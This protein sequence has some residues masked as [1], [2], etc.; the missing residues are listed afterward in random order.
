MSIKDLADKMR[1]YGRGPDDVLVHMSKKE[2]RS[3]QGLAQAAG[4]SLTVNPKT[5]LPEAGFLDSLLPTIIGGAVGVMTMN[6]MAGAA[7][8]AAVGGYQ[9]KDTQL[10]FLGGAALGAMGGYGGAN[11]AGGLANTGANA[12]ATQGVVNAVPEATL[13]QEAAVSSVGPVQAGAA[14]PLSAGADAAY[15]GAADTARMNYNNMGAMDRFSQGA[16]AAM[17]NPYGYIDTL[18]GGTEAAKTAGMAAAPAV[19][20]SML[21]DPISDDRE[22]PTLSKYKY[23]AGLTGD[24]YGT[25]GD[26]STRERQYFTQPTFTR[27][28]EGGQVPSQ[29]MSGASADA[30]NRLSGQSGA[31]NAAMQYLSGQTSASPAAV[32]RQQGIAALPAAAAAPAAA[33][34]FPDK[35]GYTKVADGY[36]FDPSAQTFSK[37]YRYEALPPP[38]TTTDYAGGYAA[39]GIVS[40]KSGDVVVPA[41]VTSFAGDGSTDAGMAVLA[42][43]MGAEPI[44]G[45]G[46]G[47]SDDIPASIDGRQ[48][49]LVANGEMVVRQPK[50]PQKVMDAIRNIRK[51]AI[52]TTKQIRPVNV[53]KALA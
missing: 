45:Q 12:A 51:Q 47:Q 43:K 50:N 11:L 10:G 28:A 24:Y 41:D 31:S 20:D 1:S 4:G 27:M 2:L 34:A 5:G 3:L 39:G 7:A 49:A 22:S 52:G 44:K 16:S 36:S 35:E 40:L 19:Y 53:D 37:K 38:P 14:Q 8:G 32:S 13:A 21:P 30:M 17:D 18:G 26:T 29:G 15:T 42:K 9:N 25:D 23:A 46:T 33:N 48:P 6:P